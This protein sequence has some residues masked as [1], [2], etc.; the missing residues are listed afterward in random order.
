[1][2]HG[3]QQQDAFLSLQ[4]VAHKTNRSS[5]AMNIC[6]AIVSIVMLILT[7]PNKGRSTALL[8]Q[9]C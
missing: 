9:F 5:A 1:M 3:R 4:D 2:V 6:A 7:L 8:R